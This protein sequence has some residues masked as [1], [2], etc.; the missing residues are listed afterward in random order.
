M[1]KDEKIANYNECLLS[2]LD[3]LK[4]FDYGSLMLDDETLS[5]VMFRKMKGYGIDLNKELEFIHL[6]PVP[7][8]VPKAGLLT[9]PMEDKAIA[10]MKVIIKNEKKFLRFATN[11]MAAHSL[12]ASHILDEKSYTL[13]IMDGKNYKDLEP[14]SD[15]AYKWRKIF[16]STNHNYGKITLSPEE[17]QELIDD[18]ENSN[19]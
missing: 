10:E 9:K 4:L 14:K 1:T 11:K 2:I 7:K 6:K 18:I 17:A 15:V 12:S 13:G 5:E 8:T 19:K 16:A 3:S